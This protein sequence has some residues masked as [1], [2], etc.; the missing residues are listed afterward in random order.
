MGNRKEP[1]RLQ[2]KRKV[3]NWNGESMDGNGEISKV[4][5]RI[6]D[7]SS[8][9]K[10]Q[11][12]SSE[13]F[14]VDG[15][16]WGIVMYPKGNKVVA[17]HEFNAM[18]LNSGFDSFIGIGELEDPKR[19]YLLND[20]CLVEAYI[21][22]DWTEDLISHE[23]ILEAGSDKHEAKETDSVKTAINNQ[24]IVKTK[25]VEPAEPTEE[26][27]KTFF[28]SL[29][30]ELSS[31]V[32]HFSKEEAKEALAKLDEALNMTPLNF[33]DSGKFSSL[34]KAF[35]ILAGFDCSSTTLTIEQK[36]ELL[37]M[38]ESLKELA[39][40]AA[41]AVEDKS[42]LAEKES[43][44]LNI[45]RNLDGNVIRYKEVESDVKQVEQ[46]LVAL[47]A[48]RKGI[49]TSSKEMKMELEALGK[50]WA[51]YEANAKAAEE[52]E[53][54]VEAGWGRMKDF[55]SSIK[56]KFKPGSNLPKVIWKV[57]VLNA[58]DDS[59]GEITKVTWRI[60]NF[61][62]FKD[63]KLYSENFIVD[64]NKWRIL[65]FPKGNKTLL[66]SAVTKHEFNA[67][68]PD[69]G[70][71]SFLPHSV[72]HDPER[73][74]L[75]NDACLVEA[76]VSTGETQGLISHEFILENDSDKHE[77]K[78]DDGVKAA[79]DNQTTMKT[80]AAIEPEDPTDEDMNTFF[81]SLES[82]LLSSKIIVSREEAE[83]AV[84]KLEDVMNMTPVDFYNSSRFSTL[85][86]PFKILASFNCSSTTLTIEQKNKLLAME[87][88][89]KELADRAAKAVEDMNHLSEKQ[90]MKL[91]IT[92][93]LDSNVVRYKEM[94]S[95][96]KRVEQKLAA[97]HEQV[98][99]AQKEMESMLAERK[100]IF[101]SSK[102]MKVELEAL[103]KK[104]A[105]YE[106]KAEVAETE[107]KTVEA[108]WERM[109]DFISSIK[110]KI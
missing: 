75:V 69:W 72:L 50:E 6:D 104:W 63:Q 27:I 89:M 56:G 49:F 1:T 43:I 4:T 17:M 101:R 94:E 64:G 67:K 57:E 53:K 74:Y 44:K 85:K 60:Q 30:S 73:G 41:K 9:K 86:Q 108:E 87:E 81:S 40:R 62:R 38:E 20:A 83:E 13:N 91:T 84:A 88:S 3:L 5:W 16:K 77:T 76:Y 100:G 22:I 18:E 103:E 95:E 55:I 51:A 23:L 70:F 96:V 37:A 92:H 98:E 31:S 25:P 46:K 61:S 82:E 110:G 47:L 52:E 15:N 93:S 28:T 58:V 19:G 80:E 26:D 29:E 45:T 97:F 21:F 107:E 106:A 48:E 2:E 33:Y 90:S 10:E 14:T 71:A 35:K 65:I 79:I 12:L 11:R 42:Q 59:N 78:G 105:E 8:I 66:L 32:T 54:T 36:N 39:D 7:F 109:K 68:E 99:E 24:T 34:E 102:R